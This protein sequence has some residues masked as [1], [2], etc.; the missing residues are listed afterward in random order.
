MSE[1]YEIREQIGE[2]GLGTVHRAHDRNLD[3]EVAIK[4]VSTAA[5][6]KG[7]DSSAMAAALLKEARTISA[8]MHPNIVTVFDAGEDDDGPYVVME[9]LK[10]ETLEDTVKR[11]ALPLDDFER[12]VQQALE[13]V[14]AAHA[15]NLV[16]RDLKP[17]NL[18]VIWLPSGK[19][20]I[21]ILDFGLAQFGQQ[22]EIDSDAHPSMLGSIHYMAPEQFENKPVTVTADVYALGAVF[23]FALTGRHPFQGDTAPQVMASHLQHSCVPLARLRPDLPA[24]LPGWVDWLMSRQPDDRP[25]TSGQALEAFHQKRAGRPGPEATAPKKMMRKAA[26]S[27]APTAATDTAS[28]KKMMRPAAGGQSA[29]AEPPRKMMKKATA[30]PAESAPPVVLPV[31]SPPVPGAPDQIVTV[32]AV[33]DIGDVVPVTPVVAAVAP[34]ED[35]ILTEEEALAMSGSHVAGVVRNIPRWAF[36]TLPLLIIVGLGW[37]SMVLIKNTK[38]R[39]DQ[40]RFVELTEQ[41]PPR[42]SMDD[43]RLIAS[44]LEDPD[45]SG[46]AARL[47]WL[48]DGENP[49]AVDQEI[50]RQLQRARTRT[51]RVNLI[52]VAGLRGIPEATPLLIG[53]TRDQDAATRRAAWGALGNTATRSEIGALVERIDQI[54]G[55]ERPHA[56]ETIITLAR[57]APDATEG[58]NLLMIAYRAAE[59]RETKQSMFRIMARLGGERAWA[60]LIQ[61]LN[62]GPIEIRRD[63]AEALSSWPTHEP[64]PELLRILQTDTDRALRQISSRSAGMLA[65]YP[66]PKSQEQL[67]EIFKNSLQYVSDPRETT[68]LYTGMAGLITP[69]AIQ[70]FENLAPDDPAYGN[71]SSYITQIRS[72]LAKVVDAPTQGSADFPLRNL[73]LMTEGPRVMN[74]EILMNWTYVDDWVALHLF[75]G[76]PGPLKLVI[77]QSSDSEEPGSLTVVADRTP[78]R[79]ETIPTGSMDEFT[80]LALGTFDFEAP[81]HY[82]VWLQPE[83]IPGDEFLRVR[84]AR[85]SR[86]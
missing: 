14:I 57:S 71:R 62:G 5:L 28:P 72:Q 1:R 61:A 4:R 31:A 58:V 17:A 13:G 84:S 21:K 68:F 20:Q 43:L 45:H 48:F 29:P 77:E 34:S 2:G 70:F 8:L 52:R 10:G 25:A 74:G 12:L 24:W 47:M 79:V 73:H 54:T 23:Y 39:A 46:I 65:T 80:E 32:T 7:T 15:V 86:D 53:L 75:V 40:A 51:A 69:D 30:D 19:F 55:A 60:E 33:E 49:V 38:Q 82:R 67:L 9:L 11:G 6:R 3:R 78:K 85:L 26:P 81:G 83:E 22:A 41:D 59:Q 18:M 66:G 42:G 56:E 36:V 37:G 76:E 35:L 16:H 64:V 27:F 44:Y 50:L 63:A